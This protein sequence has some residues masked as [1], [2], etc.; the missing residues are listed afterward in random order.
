MTRIRGTPLRA[1]ACPSSLQAGSTSTLRTDTECPCIGCLCTGILFGECALRSPLCLCSLETSTVRLYV[2]FRRNGVQM[3][4][5]AVHS[6]VY[7]PHSTMTSSTQSVRRD[8]AIPHKRGR[9]AIT[10]ILSN[11]HV[12]FIGGFHYSLL[13]WQLSFPSSSLQEWRMG[14]SKGSET[15]HRPFRIMWIR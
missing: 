2:I 14:C 10:L 3:G 11:E 8:N 13:F 6:V 7:S 4:P 12:R 1:P 9:R 15:T 5:A